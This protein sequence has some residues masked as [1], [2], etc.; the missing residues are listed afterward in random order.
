MVAN[1]QD[2]LTPTSVSLFLLWLHKYRASSFQRTTL[3]TWDPKWLQKCGALPH[4]E[5]HH[6]QEQ[7][8]DRPG[9]KME[10]MD[11]LLRPW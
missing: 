2:S 10:K 5:S 11:L 8:L 9:I 6:H 4:L 7:S 3:C 1:H